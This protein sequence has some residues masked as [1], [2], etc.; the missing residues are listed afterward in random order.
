MLSNISN[1]WTDALWPIDETLT[2]TAILG[3]GG[4]G[5]NDNEGVIHTPQISRTEISQLDVV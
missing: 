2:V 3:L 4:A 1:F 5:S